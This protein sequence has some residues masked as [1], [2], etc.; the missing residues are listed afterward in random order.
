[1]ASFPALPDQTGRTVLVTGANSGLGLQTTV[2]LAGAG[3]RVLMAC[4]DAGRA[5]AAAD[6]VRAAVPGAA[7]EIVPLDLGDLASVERA[8]ADVAGRTDTLDV[9]VNNAG[10]MAPPRRTT[11]DG[12][13]LQL[14]T[15]HLGHFALT[16][17]LLPLLLATPGSRVVTTASLAHK[18]GMVRLD[19]LMREKRYFRWE[20]Y[21]QSK[22][23]NLLF[24]FALQRRLTDAAATTI[25]VAAHPGVSATNLQAGGPLLGLPGP[26]K[27]LLT[28]VL[29]FGGKVIGQSDAAGAQPQIVA[30]TSADV[31]GGDYWGPDGLA[32]TRGAPVR[33]PARSAAHDVALQEGLWTASVELTGVDFA[34]LALA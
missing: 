1:M 32:E 7:V 29:S 26:L 8:A 34:A 23:A 30:A 14:G 15:N 24:T 10:V 17:R 2:A 20:A 33:V 12:F 21:G 16:G 27:A 31:R 4:R 18:Q 13:E 5:A 9:L 22:L 25:A 3:A 11:A 6:R 19:D 28:P